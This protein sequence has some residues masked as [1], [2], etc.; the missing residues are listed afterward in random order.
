[1]VVVIAGVGT[2]QG[3][4]AA[5]K[6]VEYRHK[7]YGVDAA[8][9]NELKYQELV[10]DAPMCYFKRVDL[11]NEMNFLWEVGPL[12]PD[13]VVDCTQY[14]KETQAVKNVCQQKHWE[15]HR[16]KAE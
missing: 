11:E 14:P 9:L 1:M 3:F 7:V 15:Y 12:K 6:G 5:C 4:T 10:R 2:E 13:M 8:D 16:F